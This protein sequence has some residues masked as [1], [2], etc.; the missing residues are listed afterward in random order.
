MDMQQV[1]F[2]KNNCRS[3]SG[4]TDKAIATLGGGILGAG[5]GIW[6][7]IAGCIVG[8]FLGC[9]AAKKAREE[10]VA[11]FLRH[12]PNAQKR[13]FL[14]PQTDLPP[15]YN[16]ADKPICAL[17]AGILATGLGGGMPVALIGCAAG[18]FL[19]CLMEKKYRQESAVR[20]DF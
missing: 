13:K 2:A 12:S 6:G 15:R 9:W 18:Y 3:A 11:R 4:G 1:S 16:P 20:R 7:A 5:L 19:A 14:R 17:G 10:A 8:Y